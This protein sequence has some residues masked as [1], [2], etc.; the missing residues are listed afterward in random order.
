[1]SV[2]RFS[3]SL[4]VCVVPVYMSHPAL[5]LAA[6]LPFCSSSSA[7]REG[8]KNQD[9][10]TSDIAADF[11]SVINYEM[12]E[13]CREKEREDHTTRLEKGEW[14]LSYGYIIWICSTYSISTCSNF[15]TPSIVAI[16][17][18]DAKL[19][20]Q[21]LS[22]LQRQVFWRHSMSPWQLLYL[23]RSD[24]SSMQFQGQHWSIS[25]IFYILS[26]ILQT[27]PM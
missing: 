1:M 19:T 9:C 18:R 17:E 6:A 15:S 24:L 4:S 23:S 11:S 8:K 16:T 14:I 21:H 20:P 5:C 10:V 2:L 22:K 26:Y 12:K 3:V 13:I 27:N 25:V 7:L